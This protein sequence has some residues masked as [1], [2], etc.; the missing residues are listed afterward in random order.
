MMELNVDMNSDADTAENVS[1][2]RRLR[3]KIL[4]ALKNRDTGERDILRWIYELDCTEGYFELGYESLWE[5]AEKDFGMDRDERSR[6]IRVA[7]AS[8]AVPEVLDA[9]TSGALKFTNALTIASLMTDPKIDRDEKLYWVERAKLLTKERLREE[10]LDEKPD[11]IARESETLRRR[12]KTLHTYTVVITEE[13]RERLL[14]LRTVK[15]TAKIK[16]A[17]FEAIDA[18]LW[19]ADPLEKAKRAVAR[20][21]KR[22]AAAQQTENSESAG[23]TPST[24]AEDRGTGGSGTTIKF[25]S[26]TLNRHIATLRDG[27]VCQWCDPE[28][29][30]KCE[31]TYFTEVHH[32]IP[33]SQGGTDDVD[34]LITLCRHHHKYVH[35]QGPRSS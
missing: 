10:I 35:Y 18:E 28:T 5:C 26:V 14:R 33:R 12:S 2:V 21:E 23:K 8:R 32:I 15:R 25:Q 34:N 7:R 20:E 31:S 17:L 16:Q 30:E 6:F 4:R 22:Q 27:G 13:E 9:V 1:D 11:V 24:P 19:A 29:G 3:G